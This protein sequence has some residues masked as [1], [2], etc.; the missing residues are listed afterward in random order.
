MSTVGS[1]EPV[2]VRVGHAEL[3]SKEAR[4]NQLKCK[5]CYSGN[6]GPSLVH[7]NFMELM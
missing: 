4:S 5:F 3:E 6:L 2:S 1:L 7:G